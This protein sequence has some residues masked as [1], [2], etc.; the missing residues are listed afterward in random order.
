MKNSGFTLVELLATIAIISILGVISVGVIMNSVGSAKN[1]LDKYQEEMLIST[2][3][4]YFDDNVSD[5]ELDQE[6]NICIQ[7]NLVFDGYLDEY[8][9]SN[10]APYNGIIKI[11][12]KEV[13]NVIKLTSSIS[14][15]TESNCY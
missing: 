12:P 5:F 9:D 14:M 15:G 7:E 10:G 4:L 3:E 6:Y 1:D 13:N 8:V 2:A 11:I